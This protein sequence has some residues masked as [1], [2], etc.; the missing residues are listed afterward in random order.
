[1]NHDPSLTRESL[2]SKETLLTL[3]HE[4][5]QKT[6]EATQDDDF[7]DLCIKNS[8]DPEDYD[9]PAYWDTFA[10]YY[11]IKLQ[12][13]GVDIV[14]SDAAQAEL[15]SA[16]TPGAIG[17]WAELHSPDKSN[18]SQHIR[19]L[20][21]YGQ[22]MRTFAN[23]H[24]G[25]SVNALGTS[26]LQVAHLTVAS[27]SVKAQQFASRRLKEELVGVQ[28]EVGFARIIEAAGYAYEAANTDQDLAGIDYVVY[29]SEHASVGVD[30][31]SSLTEIHT[32][33]ASGT[34]PYIIRPDGNIVIYSCLEPQHFRGTF[35]IPSDVAESRAPLLRDAVDN[36]LRYKPA[37]YS[38]TGVAR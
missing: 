16:N 5:R 6:F 14:S 12:I 34:L 35:D 24:R 31:K 36:A 20:S 30:V 23:N 33:A 4:A 26:L 11:D 29:P 2:S 28:H 8:V 25:T 21:R 27:D 9:N 17:H 38:T 10:R 1:M 3:F 15:L 22:L 32:S 7:A 18:K 19:F 37:A 13:Q